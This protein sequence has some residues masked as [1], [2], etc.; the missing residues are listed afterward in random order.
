MLSDTLPL[1]I[2]LPNPPDWKRLGEHFPY[3]W[4]EAALVASGKASIRL[5]RLPAQQ[6]VWLV[7]ELAL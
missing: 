4:V 5:R 6:V 1:V 7:I 2:A 3:E